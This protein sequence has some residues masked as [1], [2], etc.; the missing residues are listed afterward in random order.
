[1]ISAEVLEYTLACR[2]A[3]G[4]TLDAGGVVV[5]PPATKLAD[6]GADRLPWLSIE[7]TTNGIRLAGHQ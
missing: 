2:P 5:S 6:A 1:M 3:G 4:A 7:V